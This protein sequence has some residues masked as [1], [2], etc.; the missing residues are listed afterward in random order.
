VIGAFHSQTQSSVGSK[1]DTDTSPATA[2]EAGRNPQGLPGSSRST[3][4]RTLSSSTSGYS[5]DSTGVSAPN[6]SDGSNGNATGSYYIK[7]FTGDGSIS[8]SGWPPMDKWISFDNFWKLNV[9]VM[10]Q[11]CENFDASL[12]QNS[13]KEIEDMRKS[14]EEMAAETKLDKTFIAAI[15]MQE[16]NGCTRVHTTA[17]SHSNPGLFQSHDGTGS[18]H[19]RPSGPC[20][21]EDIFQ[22][23]KDGVGGTPQGDGLKQCLEKSR[24]SHSVEEDEAVPYYRAARL[25]NSGSPSLDGDLGRNGITPCYCSDVANRLLGWTLGNSGCTS[26]AFLL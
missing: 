15:M 19:D 12:A 7:T 5:V 13:D 8:S 21:R 22:M 2:E 25:Y 24:D 11:S 1:L 23:V 16:S 9:H 3:T 6:T 14:I 18:C 4:A 17:L 20:P 26:E 10:K